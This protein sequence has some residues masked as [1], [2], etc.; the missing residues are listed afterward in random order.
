MLGTILFGAIVG[1]II[2]FIFWLVTKNINK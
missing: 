1:G 2:G